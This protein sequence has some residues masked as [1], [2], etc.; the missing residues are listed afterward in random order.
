MSVGIYFDN[1]STSFPKP[2]IINDTIEGYL[3]DAGCSPGRS[4]HARARRSESLVN[5]ARQQVAYML[6]V[7]NYTKISYT[8]NATYA[9]NMVI[10]GSVDRGDHVI[11]TCFEHN[12]VLRPLEKL[13]RSQIIDYSVIGLNKDLEIDFI[14]YKN[15]FTKN[16]KLV[17]L[18]HASN[19]TGSI[20]PLEKFIKVAHQ[21]NAKVLV[22]LSQTAG[23]LD[24]NIS[25]WDVDFAVFTGHKSL[26]GLPG[27]GGLYVKSDREL[28]T[29]IE[30]GTGVNS[31][32]LVQPGYSPEKF[33]AGTLNYIG[34]VVLGKCTQYIRDIGL[35]R[36]REHE[37]RLLDYISKELADLPEVQLVGNRN[38]LEKIPILSF[39]IKNIPSNEVATILDSKY[40]I[41]TRPGLQCAP[42]AHKE[43]GTSPNGAVR[44]SF[45]GYD[46]TY[47]ECTS[48]INAVNNIISNHK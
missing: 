10:K 16:T 40:N 26:L 27:I 42:L 37:Y 47:D 20:L 44:I 21:H 8:Y 1:A 33:E 48:L 11:T 43:L 18:N 13:K 24:I 23:F 19:V 7:D 3:R 22:D 34:I 4:G 36:I 15:A 31:I 39:N 25:E 9:L 32:S 6:G 12:S 41:M 35:N 28:S 2:S 14:S 38:I 5:K 30:G 29:I 46:N 45:L 17:V